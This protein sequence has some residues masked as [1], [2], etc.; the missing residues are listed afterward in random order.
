MMCKRSK[1]T[2]FLG[3]LIDIV[4]KTTNINAQDFGQNQPNTPLNS[5]ANTVHLLAKYK[6]SNL[7]EDTALRF[8]V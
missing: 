5:Y 2:G 3:Y 7:E 6:V 1:E 8:V 4:D